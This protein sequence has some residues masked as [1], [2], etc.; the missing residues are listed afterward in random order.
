MVEQ[1]KMLA[2]KESLRDKVKGSSVREHKTMQTFTE[3]AI[4]KALKESEAR[5][6]RRQ[7]R[8]SV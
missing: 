4:R 8:E 5:K 1:N 6:R 3:A 2:V 7:I